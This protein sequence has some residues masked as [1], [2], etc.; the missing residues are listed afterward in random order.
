M[1]SKREQKNIYKYCKNFGAFS[2]KLVDIYTK[3]KN[4]NEREIHIYILVREIDRRWAKN[5]VENEIVAVSWPPSQQKKK[6]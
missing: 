1:Y 5:A 3:Y 6:K 4:A 2:S